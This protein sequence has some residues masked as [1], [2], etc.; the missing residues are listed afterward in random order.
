MAINGG[1][2]KVLVYLNRSCSGKSKDWRVR[3][4][5]E[6][7]HQGERRD[8]SQQARMHVLCS[9][10][11]VVLVVCAICVC[12]VCVLYVCCVCY[13]NVCYNNVCCVCVLRVCCGC[14]ICDVCVWCVCVM[15][16]WCVYVMCVLCILLCMCCVCV[17]YVCCMCSNQEPGT[18]LKIG[19][20]HIP[21]EGSAHYWR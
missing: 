11:C 16:V 18:R 7:R 4:R 15:C 6:D 14:C 3:G 19:A 1:A 10:S 2:Y 17:V 9:T 12:Y 8:W 21:P 20:H 13:N 5:I